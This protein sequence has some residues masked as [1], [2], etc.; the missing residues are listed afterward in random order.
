[1]LTYETAVLTDA[2]HRERAPEKTG[3][4]WGSV[5]A[6]T[7]VL[8]LWFGVV[9]IGLVMVLKGRDDWALGNRGPVA[10]GALVIGMMVLVMA[11]WGRQLIGGMV[12][13]RRR[14]LLEEFARANGL[15]YTRSSECSYPGLV[16]GLGEHRYRHDH[17]TT[18]H[19][20]MVDAG[21]FQ[22]TLTGETGADAGFTACYAAFR[23]PYRAPHLLLD[24]RAN[25]RG[26]VSNLPVRVDRGQELD[27]GGEFAKVWRVSAPDGYGPDAYQLLTPDVM[28][29][30]LQLPG[31]FDIEVVDQWLFLF[32]SADQLETPAFWRQLVGVDA[33]LVEPLAGHPYRDRHQAS[34]AESARA[35]AQAA[36]ARIGGRARWRPDPVLVTLLVNVGGFSLLM[37]LLGIFL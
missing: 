26:P 2:Q 4:D 3:T 22:A 30:L 34:P 9:A 37:I 25:D 7:I 10:N 6:L 16:F 18:A 8:A 31:E 33:H 13:G 19:G 11:S 35:D 36:P 1:M 32:A 23:L 20:R 21:R 5:I 17:L 28:E 14:H 15:D 12:S 24:R 27:V 29:A